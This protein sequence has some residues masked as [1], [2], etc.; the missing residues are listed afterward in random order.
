MRKNRRILEDAAASDGEKHL[1]VAWKEI[2][3]FDP[4]LRS[5]ARVAIENHPP[6]KLDQLGEAQNSGLQRAMELL[7]LARVDAPADREQVLS[8]L[9]ALLNSRAPNDKERLIALRALELS[10]I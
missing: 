3:S 1:G 5:A 7:T 10:F 4:F 9:F 8:K 2:D 6:H